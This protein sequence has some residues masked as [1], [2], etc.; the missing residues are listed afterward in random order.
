MKQSGDNPD[1]FNM[2]IVGWAL[3]ALG[4][5]ALIFVLTPR[6]EPVTELDI[7]QVIRMSQERLISKIVV[8]GDELKITATSGEQYKSKK[9]SGISVFELLEQK[10]VDTATG[11]ITIEVSDRRTNLLTAI[12]PFLPLLLFAGLMFWLVSRTRGGGQ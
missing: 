6:A 2:G 9:E 5:L 12:L 7:G 3:L 8:Q 4:L 11:G 1:T 10:G